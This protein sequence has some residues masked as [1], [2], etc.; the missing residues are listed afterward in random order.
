MTSCTVLSVY[1]ILFIIIRKIHVLFIEGVD[2]KTPLTY[3]KIT[4]K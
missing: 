1:S 3:N 2:D 4:K